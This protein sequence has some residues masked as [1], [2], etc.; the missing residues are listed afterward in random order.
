LLAHLLLS[1]IIALLIVIAWQRRRRG[2]TQTQVAGD[3]V[4]LQALKADIAETNANVAELA[5]EMQTIAYALKVQLTADLRSSEQQ[6]PASVC[7]TGGHLLINH[8]VR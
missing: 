1:A 7:D 2:S 8:R 3:Q 4:T 6:G 5:R